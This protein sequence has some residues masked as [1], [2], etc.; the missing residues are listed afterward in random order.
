MAAIIIDGKAEAAALRAEV[1]KDVEAF[2]ER[3]GRSPGLVGCP[4]R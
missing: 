2:R 4:G 3:H 1:A